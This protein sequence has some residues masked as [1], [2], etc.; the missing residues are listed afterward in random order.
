MAEMEVGREAACRFDLGLIPIRR[1]AAQPVGQEPL[2]RRDGGARAP[3]D[4][5]G[6]HGMIDRQLAQA[7]MSSVPQLPREIGPAPG[8]L[9]RQLRQAR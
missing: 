7:N 4:V 9:R 8:D 6:R 1:I 2:E 3:P 5:G